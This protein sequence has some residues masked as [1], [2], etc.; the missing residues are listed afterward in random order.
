MQNHASAERVDMKAARLTARLPGCLHA[1]YAI[2]A[3]AMNPSQ[4]QLFSH[5]CFIAVQDEVYCQ[6]V[7]VIQLMI[8]LMVQLM[9]QLMVQLMIQLM[10]QLM[11]Q[12]MVQLMIQLMTHITQPCVAYQVV[13]FWMALPRNVVQV[14]H[15]GIIGACLVSPQIMELNHEALQG[16]KQVLTHGIPAE[17]W[18]PNWNCLQLIG[19]NWH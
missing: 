8:Q 1:L 5:P 13:A 11:I 7:R 4:C 18:A 17:Q 9:I 16:V 6:P 10:V 14:R 15:S 2:Y 3:P 12:L 19:F